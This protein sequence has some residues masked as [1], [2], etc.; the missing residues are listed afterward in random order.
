MTEFVNREMPIGKLK[1]SDWLLIGCSWLI[2]QI[3]LVI[4]LGINSQ[5]ESLKYIGLADSWIRGHQHFNWNQIFYSGYV[6]IHVVL[7]LIGLPPQAMYHIQLIFSGIAVIYFVKIICLFIRIRPVIIISAILFSTC[8]FIQQWVCALFTDSLFGSLLIIAIYYLLTEQASAGNK[9]ICRLFLI[10]LPFFRPVGILFILLACIYWLCYPKKNKKK[11]VFFSIYLILVG[12]V[13]Y[14][15]LVGNPA[16]FYPNHNV[17]ANIIC[18]YPGNLLKYQRSPYRDQT[19]MLVYVSENPGMFVRLF[20]YRFFKV[21][22]MTRDYFSRLHNSLLGLS[23]TFYLI[24][25]LIG[26]FSREWGKKDILILLLSGIL[27]FSIPS[28]L[29]CVEWSGRFSLPVYCFILLLGSFGIKRIW[30]LTHS[31]SP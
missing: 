31:S 13:V 5:Q 3:A 8:F 6:I 1:K 16:Y 11:L 15:S 28:V 19:G 27:I 2:M 14:K 4:Y 22:S 7:K 12:T 23:C 9:L 21:F 26:S 10:V 18:G 30:E 17:E 25:A 29:F 24:M 20:F